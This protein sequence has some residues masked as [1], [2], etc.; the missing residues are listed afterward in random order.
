MRIIAKIFCLFSRVTAVGTLIVTTAFVDAQNTCFTHDPNGNTLSQQPVVAPAPPVIVTPPRDALLQPGG[1]VR[2]NVVAGGPGPVTYQW[3]HNGADLPGA[4]GDV[5]VVPGLAMNL[6]DYGQYTVVVSNGPASSTTSA[7]ATVLPDSNL[8][9]VADAVELQYFTTLPAIGDLD[10]DGDGVT[11]YDEIQHGS[12][13]SVYEHYLLNRWSWFA[14]SY[15]NTTSWDYRLTP[16][17]SF[18]FQMAATDHPTEFTA[19]PLPPGLTLNTTTGLI[20][21]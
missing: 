18:Q 8:N 10:P 3:R 2:F 13:P 4:T 11:I 21:G 12:D 1:T 6:P 17:N 15:E 19:L 14:Q 20:T 7:S 5:M 16:G 9:G